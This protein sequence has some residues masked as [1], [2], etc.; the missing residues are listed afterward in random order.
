IKLV[1]IVDA[2]CHGNFLFEQAVNSSIAFAGH[3]YARQTSGSA[4]LV[5]S[6]RLNVNGS[7][8][9]ARS[10]DPSG[11]VFSD[12]ESLHLLLQRPQRAKSRKAVFVSRARHW[13]SRNLR[14]LC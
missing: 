9:A 1:F 6:A 14:K 10:L 3:G 13:L 2:Q 7:I 8:I 4:G 11:S 12:K 5:R